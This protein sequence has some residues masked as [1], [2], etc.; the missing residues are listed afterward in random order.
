MTICAHETDLYEQMWAIAPYADHSPGERFLPVFLDL[1]GDARGTVLD[2]GDLSAAGVVPA[3]SAFPFIETPLWGDLRARVGAARD[4]VYCCDVLEHIPT[5][6]TMLAAAR[7]IEVC[8]RGA[9]FSICLQPD[10]FGSWV[11]QPLHQTVQSFTWW[12]DALGELGRVTD[13][14]DLAAT[15]LYFVEPA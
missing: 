6:F 5:A 11:G 3:A 2:A 4:W 1:V 10:V 15:G 7:M 12:R 9:F 14:R 13:C 8:R